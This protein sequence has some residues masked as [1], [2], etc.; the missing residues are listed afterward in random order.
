MTA[1]TCKFLFVVK[2]MRQLYILT[3]QMYRASD[4]LVLLENCEA[5]FGGRNGISKLAYQ[6]LKYKTKLTPQNC[7]IIIP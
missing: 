3:S 2:V 7:I 4:F 1:C 6:L 5:E